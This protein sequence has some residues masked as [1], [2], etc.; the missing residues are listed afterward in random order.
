MFKVGDKVRF[1]KEFYNEEYFK[2]LT[3]EKRKLA[4]N[5]ASL[6]EFEV[7][8]VYES[9]RRFRVID[10]FHNY[11]DIDASLLE[12]CKEP[13]KVKAGDKILITRYQGG[14]AVGTVATVNCVIETGIAY[15]SGKSKSGEYYHWAS[16]DAYE[17][18]TDSEVKEVKRIAKVG[19]WIK[20]IHA[21]LAGSYY[22]NGDILKVVRIG[23]NGVYIECGT[24]VWSNE[25]IVLEGYNPT[26]KPVEV[27]EVSRKAKVGDFIKITSFNCGD[28]IGTVAEVIGVD[29]MYARYK[30]NKAYRGYYF[31][32][33]NGYEIVEPPK[34]KWTEEEIVKAKCFLAEELVNGKCKFTFDINNNETTCYNFES[35]KIKS[36]KCAYNDECN[37]YIGAVVAYCRTSGAKIPEFIQH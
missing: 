23:E 31:A 4:A 35:N 6:G 14:D 13:A 29:E 34:R 20:I 18:V 8:C 37:R 33:H 17:L 3:R 9:I 21:V 27:K 10:K 16:N 19:E 26:P 5:T 36:A 25:Y 22:K 28:K 15:K 12:L 24:V 11:Y 7:S 1:K 2:G 30:S 32:R